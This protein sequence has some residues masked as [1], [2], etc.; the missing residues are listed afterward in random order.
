MSVMNE[1]YTIKVE[2][3]NGACVEED[4]CTTRPGVC[5]SGTCTN[6]VGSPYWECTCNSG[7]ELTNDYCPD[8]EF[9]LFVQ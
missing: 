6:I 3:E 2:D 7:A 9:K 4:E 8:C 5:A 1:N